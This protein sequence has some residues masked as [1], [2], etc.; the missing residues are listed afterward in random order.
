MKNFLIFCLLSLF[1]FGTKAQSCHTY[2]NFKK[3]AKMEMTSYDKKDKPALIIKYEIKDVKNTKDGNVLKIPNET[4]DSKGKSIAI[5]ELE[6][7]CQNGN[8]TT[9]MRSLMG[10]MMPQNNPNVTINITG[11]KLVY[12][13]NM[14]PGDK[15]TDASMTMKTEMG[16]MTLMNMTMHIIERQVIGQETVTTTAGTFDCLKISY[17]VNFKMMGNRSS[18][19]IEYLAKGIGL[20]KSES[21]DEKG[22]KTGSTALTSLSN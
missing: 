13:N 7:T 9:D 19:S 22:K 20:V 11:D 1:A 4:L 21:F 18:K 17:T 3:G 2:F 6:S 16:G 10:A 14:K 12:P 8:Y 15:L 5:I